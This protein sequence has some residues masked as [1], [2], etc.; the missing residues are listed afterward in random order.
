MM[1]KADSGLVSVILPV[2]NGEKTIE[3]TVSSVLDQTYGNI[4]IIIADDA[5]SDNTLDKCRSL[6]GSDNRIRIISNQANM[7][8]LGTRLKAAKTAIGEWIAFI[9]SDDLWH[10]EKLEK[11]I[12]LRDDTGCDLVYTASAF[13][14][15]D[16]NKYKWIMH[17]PEKVG[18]RK[19][20][21][22]NIISN[23]SVLVRK[24]VFI[25]YSSP[26]EKINNMH[27]D[28]ACWLSMLRDGM[29]A[30]G[31]NEPLITYRISKRSKSGNKMSAYTMNM[32]T[33]RYLGLGFFERYFYQA[34]YSV[35]GLVKYSHFK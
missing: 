31:V 5:S 23:S 3:A 6:A 25:R 32:N 24:D 34:C 16:G 33:Y 18:Y 10:S 35:N 20:L 7:G 27:E 1:V 28:F 29:T 9:D 26:C 8:A 17:V 2:Y 22:Q 12:G 19:L 13:I 4:E 30:C 21:K 15:G 14:D 11:Q